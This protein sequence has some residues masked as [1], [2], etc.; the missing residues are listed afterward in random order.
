MSSIHIQADDSTESNV[1]HLF[2][3]GGWDSTFRLLQLLFIENKTVQPHY[4][5]DENRRSCWKEIESKISIQY[6]LLQAYPRLNR[7]LR[8]TIYTSITEVQTDQSLTDSARRIKMKL[9]IDPQYDWLSRYCRQYDIQKMDLCI[10]RFG[11]KYRDD[12]LIENLKQA[13][14]E[15]FSKNDEL[16]NDISYL[17]SCFHLP[18]LDKTKNQLLKEAKKQDWMEFMNKTWFC[19]YPLFHP[20]K[21]YVPCSACVT[22][23]NQYKHDFQWRIPLYSRVVQKLSRMKHRL[24][25][26]LYEKPENQ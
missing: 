18:F 16:L 21:G 7:K 5:I 11:G 23:R 25:N 14:N 2:W 8:P 12:P 6:E 26:F 9:K 20:L 19:Y 13:K 4:I 24:D 15:T 17:F 1:V 3:T 22:C 10:I